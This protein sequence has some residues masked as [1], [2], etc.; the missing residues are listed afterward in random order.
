MGV[1]VL[2]GVDHEVAADSVLDGRELSAPRGGAR[3]AE[4]ERQKDSPTPH[5][6]GSRS[7]GVLAFARGGIVTTAERS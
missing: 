1:A 7:A 3:E 4:R 6:K 5:Q 2:A